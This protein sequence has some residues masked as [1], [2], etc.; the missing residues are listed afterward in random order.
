[1]NVTIS[2]RQGSGNLNHNNRVF[3]TENVDIN[4]S[5]ENIT[6]CKENL[7]I[8]YEKC[9]GNSI[10]EYN[11]NQSRK[12]RKIDGIQG[13]INKLK[14][15]KN[16]EKI[17]YECIVQ[18]GNQL[19]M[20]NGAESIELRNKFKNILD[21]YMKNF[22]QRNPNLYV[23]NAVLHMDETTPHLH[24]NYIPVATN[25]KKG[26]SKRNSLSKALEEQGITG[27]NKKFSN[28]SI[29]WNEQEKNY[30]EKIINKYGLTREEERGYKREHLSLE[31]YKTVI[32]YADKLFNNQQ[33]KNKEIKQINKNVK[34][35]LL[36]NNN[37]IVKEEDFKKLCNIVSQ[38]ETINKINESYIKS[39]KKNKFL[40]I[41][42]HYNILKKENENLKNEIKLLK[43]EN[44]K[45]KNI[46]E[47]SKS[48]QEQIK[49]H[50]EKK[51]FEKKY[52]LAKKEKTKQKINENKKLK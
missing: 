40:N 39:I 37:L 9:F 21:T 10:N 13:Y 52:N 42:S 22:Q 11:K 15:S 44:L 7:N 35:S 45:Q 33:L 49:F 12:D 14:N 43:N 51:E 29:N 36:N 8:A 2:L 20:Y 28:N 18:V 16:G 34:H 6:Y 25:Y 46:I 5:D 32:E 48:I 38:K 30:L 24:I 26:L 41:I 47:N 31:Q 1:M 3:Y 27:E 50:K 19:D 23:F 17:F 4:M